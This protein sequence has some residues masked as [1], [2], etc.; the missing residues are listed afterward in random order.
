LKIERGG[1]VFDVPVATEEKSPREGEEI[2]LRDWGCSVSS[3]TPDVIRQARLSARQGVL[4]TG[5]Q[6]GQ[7]FHTAGV[8]QGDIVLTIDGEIVA[9]IDQFERIYEE[10]IHAGAP[11]IL[12]TVKRGALSM[13]ILVKQ[14]GGSA[15]GEAAAPTETPE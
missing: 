9:D 5:V 11:R 14:T 6:V 10:L 1:Q 3:L 15:P 4:V 13:F 12:L 2:E 8:R 7:P